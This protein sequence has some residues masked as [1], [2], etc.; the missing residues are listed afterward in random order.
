MRVSIEAQRFARAP[1]TG[2]AFGISK[3]TSQANAEPPGRRALFKDTR[4]EGCV[5]VLVSCFAGATALP[6]HHCCSPAGRTFGRALLAK[7]LF[8][9]C[10]ELPNQ[11]SSKCCSWLHRL[12][13]L[14]VAWLAAA[15]F[16]ALLRPN[17]PNV[18]SKAHHSHGLTTQCQEQTAT[19]DTKCC[20]GQSGGVIS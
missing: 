13:Q 1:D 15:V 17:E 2:A 18:F 9:L 12:I 8:I 6:A 19:I 10:S 16:R 5:A 3:S 14:A 11:H 7:L 4:T 20:R